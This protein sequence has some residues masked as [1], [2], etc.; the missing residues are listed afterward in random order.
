MGKTF[1]V[2]LVAFNRCGHENGDKLYSL[3][4]QR[5]FYGSFEL[6]PSKFIEYNRIKF[7]MGLERLCAFIPLKLSHNR[8]QWTFI[9]WIKVF[10]GLNRRYNFYYKNYQ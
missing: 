4:G 5:S 7:Y 10:I 9:D 3:T 1:Y 8:R 6:I 2:S